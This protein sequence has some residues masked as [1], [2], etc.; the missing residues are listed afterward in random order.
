MLSK[1]NYLGKSSLNIK[2]IEGTEEPTESVD[3]NEETTSVS[4]N[5]SNLDEIV[6]T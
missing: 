2:Q 5:K 4:E 1:L 3:G 6:T